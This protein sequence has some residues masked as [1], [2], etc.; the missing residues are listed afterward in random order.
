M[1]ATVEAL[2][3]AGPELPCPGSSVVVSEAMVM[4]VLVLVG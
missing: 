1:V 3:D 4:V 2:V